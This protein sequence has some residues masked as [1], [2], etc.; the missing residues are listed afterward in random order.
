MNVSSVNGG[1]GSLASQS[2]QRKP[3]VV[4][5]NRT[6]PEK[7]ADPAN[8]GS[9]KNAQPGPTTGLDGSK[10]GRVLNASA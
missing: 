1:Y 10:L 3:E 7:N 8:G 9:G 2:V 4:S 6:G 5:S